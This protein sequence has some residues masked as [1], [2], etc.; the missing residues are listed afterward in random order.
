MNVDKYTFQFASILAFLA[1]IAVFVGV[2]DIAHAKSKPS[3]QTFSHPRLL[4]EA[5]R[6]S[7]KVNVPTH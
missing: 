2:A 7:R 1:T 6:A 4:V 3:V 5:G